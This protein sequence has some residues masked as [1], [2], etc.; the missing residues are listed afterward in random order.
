MKNLA[1]IQNEIK[2]EM[3]PWE[4]W[5]YRHSLEPFDLL[6]RNFFDFETNFLPATES[7]PKYPVDIHEDENNLNIEIAV[8][9]V[10]KDDIQIEEEGNILRVTYNKEKENEEPKGDTSK[11]YIQRNIAKR[12]FSFEWKVSDKCDL[13]KI[14]ASLDKGILMIKIP[15][16]KEEAVT[17]NVI[18]IK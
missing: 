17:K 3:Q 16:N 10:E 8:A 5:P 18:K 14:D 15:K 13:K 2:N 4:K 11:R 7:H 6:F 9:G 12:S 1:K